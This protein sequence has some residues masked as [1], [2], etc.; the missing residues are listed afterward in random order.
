MV[1]TR[2]NRYGFAAKALAASFPLVSQVARQA[3]RSYFSRPSSSFRK[4]KRSYSSAISR[5]APMSRKRGFSRRRSSKRG[6]F[7]K[8][9]RESKFRNKLIHTL[10]MP[11]FIEVSTADAFQV[12][13]VVSG[14]GPTARY[15]VATDIQ[16]NNGSAQFN[17][18]QTWSVYRF[19]DIAQN[20]LGTSA[21]NGRF[22]VENINLTYN[23]T[24]QNVGH[25]NLVCYFCQFREDVSSSFS[26]DD[27]VNTMLGAGFT[28]DDP[29]N[30]V[31]TEADL[32]REDETPFMAPRFTHW[33]RIYKVKKFLL[34]AGNNQSIKIRHLKRRT[35]RPEK[36][37]LSNDTTIP[38]YN[39]SR[40]VGHVRGSKFLLCK[41]WGQPADNAVGGLVTMTQPKLDLVTKWSGEF[42]YVPDVTS[43]T[44][45]AGSSVAVPGAVVNVL[46][47]QIDAGTTDGNA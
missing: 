1:G 22:I 25:V 21:L 5:K 4:R 47:E 13:P 20:V 35:V 15:F 39:R 30:A 36:Y 16:P 9:R 11:N 24:N 12:A 34:H 10:S 18:M 38:W 44:I 42:R 43:T 14:Q 19:V 3:V 23:I 29:L 2:R 37:V 8:R 31:A 32:I 28:E 41:F 45:H 40:L 7:K 46:G 27:I 17:H 26:F 6:Y 33:V